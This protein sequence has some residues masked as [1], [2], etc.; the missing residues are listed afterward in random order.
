MKLK[1]SVINN[2]YDN[3]FPFDDEYVDWINHM[4]NDI[5]TGKIILNEKSN[6][7]IDDYSPYVTINS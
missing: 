3:A 7:V 5:A 6:I 2:E 4:E 1:E